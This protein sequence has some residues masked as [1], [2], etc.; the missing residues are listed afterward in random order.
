MRCYRLQERQL[1]D[2][3][4]AESGTGAMDL[5]ASLSISGRRWSFAKLAV[6]VC[7]AVACALLI[8]SLMLP[9][10]VKAAAGDPIGQPTFLQLSRHG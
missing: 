7:F 9:S 8:G 10:K 2:G 3:V 6:I 5:Q 1:I 4:N